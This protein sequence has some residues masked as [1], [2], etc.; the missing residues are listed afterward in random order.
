MLKFF[1]ERPIF[2]TV[3]SLFITIVGAV[4]IFNLPIAQ[5]PEL[6]PPSVEVTARY[7]GA[8][9]ETI[10]LNV[11]API[12]Q[13]VNGVD[14]M[15]YMS[16]VSSSSG[17]MTLT[18]SFN[19]GTDPDTAMINVNNKVSVAESSL[20]EEVRRYGITVEKKSTSMLQIISL[21]SPDNTL[22]TTYIGNYALVY[23]IDELKR[24]KGVG[25]AKV[26]SANDYSMRIWI[27]PDLLVK[28][29]LTTTDI[30]N[31]IN[32]QNIQSAVGKVAQEPLPVKVDRAYSIEVEG[33]FT[34]T[35]Q[36]EEIILRS[37]ADGSSLRLKDVAR[38][39]LGSQTYEFVGKL[40]G[41]PST[42]IGIYL[43][44]GANAV[45]TASAVTAKMQELEKNFPEGLKQQVTYDTTIFVTESIKEVVHTLF[46]AMILVFFV[47]FIFLKDFRATII[48]CIAVPVSI[49]GTF[50]GMLLMGFSINT[51]T[52]FGLVL[53]IGIVVDDAIIII[54]NVERIVSEEGL[55]LKDATIKTM[56][57][58]SGPLIAIVLVL[59][60]VFVPVSFMGGMTGV[61]YQQFA[62][63]IAT[64]V[65]ISGIVALTLTP[66]LCVLFLKPGSQMK[67]SWF[68]KPF[69]IFD[70]IF[71]KVTNKYTGA[72]GFLLKHSAFGVTV[73]AFLVAGALG[74]IK[75]IPGGL[76]PEEDQGIAIV[77]IMTDPGTSLA[78]TTE[79]SDKVSEFAQG[80]P[81]VAQV[82]SF[83]G[84]D[85]ITSALKNNAG[86]IFLTLKNWDERPG[87][88]L[89]VYGL[90]KQISLF[91]AKEISNAL[92]VPFN[93]P[94]IS[95][96]SATGGVEG[97]IQ[98]KGEATSLELQ[99]KVKEFSTEALKNSVVGSVTS[100]FNAMQ[101]Q[102]KFVIDRTKARSLGVSV[103]DIYSTMS[104]NFGNYYINDFT[105]MGRSFKVLMQAEGQYRMEATQLNEIFVK[106]SGGSFVPLSSVAKLE[107]IIGA[108]T[109]E[110]F[111]IFKAAKIVANPASGSSSGQTIAALES[112]AAATL[113]SDYSLSWTGSAYQEKLSGAAGLS[114]IL[115]GLVV[116]FLILSAQY[117]SWKLPLVVVCAVPF[118]LLGALSGIWARGLDNDIYF[119][120][121]LLTLIGLAAKNAILIVEFAVLNRAS[122]MGFAEAALAAARQRFRPI[123]MTS[124]A[125]ILGCTPLA[126]STGAGSS[127]RHAIGTAVIFG[128]VG[129]T[130][131][132]PMFI[133]MFYKIIASLGFKK[134]EENK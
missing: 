116:V 32:E 20:P 42:P 59:C 38:I 107:P 84:N 82:M 23:I 61:M 64:S 55:N 15:I 13:E 44:P 94:P 91:G 126:I 127:S 66:A 35:A 1:I 3:I 62:I 75:I 134:K 111:N 83:S 106:S 96:L 6:T 117:E 52:L 28:Y 130:F 37:N 50:A 63:T 11:A 70:N 53:A 54:E 72:V 19:I 68:S 57:E 31:A 29:G 87:A 99:Q 60:A 88:E 22:D 33:R 114:A 36:F 92:V 71:G 7:P 85:I 14:D 132:A 100:P 121:A 104:A 4:S 45:A 12:E 101:P 109:I 103:S 67:K 93:M 41:K 119:Q 8:S 79:V 73:F 81:Q 80:L 90:I 131:I 69:E 65:V 26:M 76:V 122:G 113:G 112:A 16:S 86:T 5:Y 25:D 58:V 95:G 30:A 39:E 43:S 46:E 40:N 49:I 74:L 125:F 133:P 48:P 98:S 78:K 21:T 47:V 108:D 129:A 115:M 24:I 102:Y 10:A 2:S 9:A 123:I 110:H 124:L 34:D 56:E 51:L 118:A 105:T 128:M 89:S 120:I 18:V 77:S 17:D 27:K 97:Y